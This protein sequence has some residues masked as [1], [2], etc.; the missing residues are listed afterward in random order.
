MNGPFGEVAT[1]DGIGKAASNISGF[2]VLAAT[3]VESG[4][5]AEAKDNEPL[6]SNTRTAHPA[7]TMTER[8]PSH[9]IRKRLDLICFPSSTSLHN[10]ATVGPKYRFIP[11]R[12]N[13]SNRPSNYLA[14]LRGRSRN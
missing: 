12:Y 1:E 11:L 2:T 3:F 4:V 6:T 9:P 14:K 8:I 10:K 13:S 7:T 5:E